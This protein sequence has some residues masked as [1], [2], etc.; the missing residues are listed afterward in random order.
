MAILSY[1]YSVNRMLFSSLP[2]HNSTGFESHESS[3]GNSLEKEICYV[4]FLNDLSD[5][6]LYVNRQYLIILWMSN[7]PSTSLRVGWN[8]LL[9]NFFFIKC[10]FYCYSEH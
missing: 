5:L 7:Y 9:Y 3:T 8:E 6:Y 1:K 2:V 4:I 10:L